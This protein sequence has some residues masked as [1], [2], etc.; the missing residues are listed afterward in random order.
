MQKHRVTDSIYTRWC[1]YA[2]VVEW[3]KTPMELHV[4]MTSGALRHLT[5]DEYQ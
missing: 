1:T 4:T 2:P 5:L 3:P